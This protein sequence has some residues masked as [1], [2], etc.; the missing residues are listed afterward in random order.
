MQDR[1]RKLVGALLSILLA[2]GGGRR[3]CLLLSCCHAD[4]SIKATF[5]YDATSLLPL[6]LLLL[7]PGVLPLLLLV[8]L[9]VLD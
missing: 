4:A 7:I 5:W 9:P 2:Q 1:Q 3:G 8:L 6:L